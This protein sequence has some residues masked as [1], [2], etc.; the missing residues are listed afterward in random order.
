MAGLSL[1]EGALFS[2]ST[3][4]TGRR[5]SIISAKSGSS[6]T[7]AAERSKISG[8]EKIQGGKRLQTQVSPVAPAVTTLRSLDW[9]RDRFDIEF[10]LQNG[11]TYNSYIIEGDQLAIIDASHE[12][13]RFQ[14]LAALKEQIDPATINY[15]IA[16]HTEPDHSG[17]IPEILKLAPDA[18]VVGS[19][20]CIQFLQN[21]V[22]TP[23]KSMVVKG[24]EKLDLG[25]GHVLEFVMAPNLHWPDTM[26][27]FDHGSKVLFTCDAFG[28]H[29]CSTATYDED[30]VTIEPHYRFY[31]DCLMKP[32]ARSVLVGLKRVKDLDF[33]VIATGHGPLL[34]YNVPELMSKYENWSKQALEKQLASVA[35]LYVSDYGYSDRLSQTFARGLTKT[36]TGAQM[37]DLNSTDSQE[38][39]ESVAR[40][41]AVFLMT[42][43][44]TGPANAAISTLYAALKTKKPVLIAE[45]Y[46]G[47]DEPVD[48]ILQRFV[49]LGIPTP[50]P[51]LRVKETPT[52]STY[53]QFEEAGTDLGQLL[54]QKKVIEAKKTQMPVNVA[55][56]IARVSGG[57]YVVTAFKGSTK[58]AMIASWVSQAS[59]KP[60]GITIAVAKDRAI[61]S[62]MQVGDNFVLNCLEEGNSTKLMKHFL[63]RFPPGADRFEGVEWTVGKNSCPILVD[64]LAY[65]ECTVVTRME[66]SDHW[67]IY[68]HATEGSVSKPDARTAV[69]HRKIG[70][71]Y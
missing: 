60:L 15:V 29:Y 3:H 52:E 30:L 48:T 31:Y 57:I 54:S 45:S 53:Q 46:G 59:F 2:A 1:G 49:E 5:R 55:K 37:I 50:L 41:S 69:H 24:G 22:L 7:I 61:E 39:V 20:V 38:I 32:N 64:A 71:Y 21:L 44:S 25:K 35:V 42:P 65:L 47:D 33:A 67:I 23:F 19:K 16:N 10:G 40:N 4:R 17:L 26:F 36:D 43:P 63:K 9:D 62:L 34:R 6:F 56:A 12:K 66:V 8:I 13:F 14:Y 28:M 18:V 68:A 27:T 11:T 58:G 70:N 51:A